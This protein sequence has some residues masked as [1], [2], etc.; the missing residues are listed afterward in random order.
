VGRMALV[1]GWRPTFRVGRINGG[2]AQST[3]YMQPMH[4]DTGVRTN[5]TY[6]LESVYPLASSVD[7][8]AF[9]PNSR[10]TRER[11]AN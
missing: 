6:P 11:A 7:W 1:N 9:A 5:V 10:C 8:L 4:R 2:D 3:R